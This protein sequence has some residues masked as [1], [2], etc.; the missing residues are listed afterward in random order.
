M[1][2]ITELESKRI[3]DESEIADNFIDA[4]SPS[5]LDYF[6]EPIVAVAENL[7]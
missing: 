5:I 3:Q 2:E 6:L 4:D 1:K 7:K